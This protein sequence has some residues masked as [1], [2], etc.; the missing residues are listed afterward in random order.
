MPDWNSP[1]EL[2]K[3]YKLFLDT[4]HVLLGVFGYDFLRTLYFEYN[5]LS[6]QRPFWR[7]L[8]AYFLGRYFMLFALL[9][10]VTSMDGASVVAIV[11]GRNDMQY[12]DGVGCVVVSQD[13]VI[14]ATIFA[15]TMGLDFVV[16]LLMAVKVRCAAKRLQISAVIALISCDGLLFFIV[17]FIFHLVATTLMLIKLNP[18]LSILFN[19]P[20]AVASTIAA[21]RAVRR[22]SDFAY[23]RGGGNSFDPEI[24]EDDVLLALLLYPMSTPNTDAQ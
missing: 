5:F 12:V 24:M 21:S 17:A 8:I 14:L 18:I 13:N 20:A 7:G 9:G 2:D 1:Q 11:A 6:R 10:M 4:L 22:L 3:S 15:Y 16:L 23:S 19:V